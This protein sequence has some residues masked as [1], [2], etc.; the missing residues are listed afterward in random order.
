MKKGLGLN[1][2][3]ANNNFSPLNTT[4][5][6]ISYYLQYIENSYNTNVMLKSRIFINS[7]KKFTTAKAQRNFLLSFR[8]KN[9]LPNNLYNI[10]GNLKHLRFYSNFGFKNFTSA[11]HIF[12]KK[13]LNIEIHYINIHV[14]FLT[15][16]IIYYTTLSFPLILLMIPDMGQLL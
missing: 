10:H 2:V 6:S 1:N 7:L 3:R 15:N 4:L 8:S 9:I 16:K 12:I 13:M 14:K 11:K 5:N